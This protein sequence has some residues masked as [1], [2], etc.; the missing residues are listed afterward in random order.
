VSTRG[1]PRN[2]IKDQNR[3]YH[4]I[5]STAGQEFSLGDVEK[6]FLMQR[7][8]K[9]SSVYFVKVFTFAILSNHFHLLVQMQPDEDYSDEEVERRFRIYYG[10]QRSFSREKVGHYRKKWSD[11]SEYVKEIKQGFSFWYNRQHNRR[12]YFWSDRFKSVVVED[13][14]ALV[15]CMAYI[16]LNAVRANLVDRP[17][18]YRF[19]GLGYHL[20]TGNK[21]RFLS[22]DLTDFSTEDRPVAAYRRFVYE[23]GSLERADGKRPIP[24]SIVDQEASDDYYIRRSRLFRYRSRYFTDSVVIG[25][26]G[27]VRGVY[28]KL[29]PYLK[30]REDRHPVRINGAKGLYSMK[31][32]KEVLS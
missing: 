3:C 10:N 2:L 6:E 31:K 9:L 21:D 29:Q 11:V 22:L 32:L 23:M 4:I 19:C 20:Q 7:I 12:G 27:F 17:E 26:K 14:D 30:T 1:I 24:K 8:K 18:E 13:G 16:D 5:S 28:G 25:S 15:S